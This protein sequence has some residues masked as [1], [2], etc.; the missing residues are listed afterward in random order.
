MDVL[1]GLGHFIIAHS[2]ELA[3]FIL[4]PVVD[5]LNKDVPNEFERFIVTILI[6][7]FTAVLTKWNLLVLGSPN[8]VFETAT[9]IFFE[10]QVVFKLYFKNSYLRYMINKPNSPPPDLPNHST[11]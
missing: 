11:I 2:T 1:I 5:Y 9:V 8:A 4:P 3:G 10:S 7:L 6:C